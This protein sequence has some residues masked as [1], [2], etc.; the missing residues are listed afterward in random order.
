MEITV[1]I[2]T[3]LTGE[4]RMSKKLYYVTIALIAVEY[5]MAVIFLY[6]CKENARVRFFELCKERAMENLSDEQ[7]A[8]VLNY[9][10]SKS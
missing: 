4:T 9:L 8:R 7:K 10:K 5:I 3:I 6:K 2:E 1:I